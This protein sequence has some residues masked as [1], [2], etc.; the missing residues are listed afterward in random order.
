MTAAKAASW[1]W[2][3]GGS[4]IG[5]PKKKSVVPGF[6]R[7]QAT[8]IPVFWFVSLALPRSVYQAV[9]ATPNFWLM[10]PTLVTLLRR[11]TG[12][13]V[14]LVFVDIDIKLIQ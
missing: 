8:S 11:T 5:R 14:L 12:S 3:E 10:A 7:P 1:L 9:A 13:G 6:I 4:S 2:G